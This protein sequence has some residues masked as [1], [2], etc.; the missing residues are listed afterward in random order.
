MIVLKDIEMHYSIHT[1]LQTVNMQLGTRDRLALIGGN[2]SG[3]STLLKIIAG[4]MVPTAGI[5]ERPKGMTLGYLPQSGLYHGGRTLWE[6]MLTALPEWLEIRRKRRELLNKIAS[7]SPE[8]PEHRRSMDEYGE[9]ETVY[10]QEDGYAQESRLKR[11]LGGLGFTGE[12]LE[13][14]V[15]VFSS[16]WQMRIGLGKLLAR[17]PD[18][19]LLDEPTDHLD[20]EAKNWLEDYLKG[21]RYGFVLVSHDRHFLD[22][23]VETVIE[24]EHCKPEV[25]TGNYTRFL[26]EKEKRVEAAEDQY[27]KQRKKIQ[28][29]ETYIARNRARKDRARQ[30]QSRIRQLDRM[31]KLEGVKRETNLRFSFPAPSRAP[32]VVL[33]LEEMKKSYPGKVLFQN[34]NLIVER[35]E[36]IAVIGPNGAG[37]STILRI[38]AGKEPAQE[39][40]RVM[41]DRVSIG[42]FSQ[43]TA[44]GLEEEGGV[45]DALLSVSPLMPQDKARGLLARFGFRGDHVFKSVTDLSGGERVRL[46]L[47]RLLLHRHHLLLLD[48]PTNHLDIKGRQALLEALL[49]Y[50]GTLVFVSH[51][52]YFIQELALRVLEIQGGMVR[53]FPG[54]YEDYLAAREQDSKNFTLLSEVTSEPEKR[55]GKVPEDSEKA[56]R[57]EER[58]ERKERKRDEQKR[59]RWIV[60]IEKEIGELE[61]E[62]RV[63]DE[64]MTDPAVARDYERLR[65][66]HDR[67]E[68]I[69]KNLKKR[70]TT[71]DELVQEENTA[72]E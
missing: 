40:F 54:N 26:K 25:Y 28:R 47:A 50:S 9:M 55:G 2:G 20:L 36:R 70:Y 56:R 69:R 24:I 37:K 21:I 62:L 19:M 17:E 72:S 5:V 23:I 44:I 34:F 3:K 12:D 42:W 41:G 32:R 64:E 45:L 15:D 52:R 61:D 43:D 66:L 57:F 13:R 1:V 22:N 59:Q 18:F 46:T 27:V 31:E 65:E 39:G 71:W 7:L 4:E 53:N 49:S 35:G 10:Q 58:T 14:Q 8:S 29:T 63:L 67:A 60:R 68:D 6:E 11:I 38:L 51:D 16:G 48:E 30:V 33:E